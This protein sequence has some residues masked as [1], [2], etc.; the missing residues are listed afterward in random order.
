M[1]IRGAI[2]EAAR[3]VFAGIHRLHRHAF[4]DDE[5]GFD[6]YVETYAPLVAFIAFEVLVLWIAGIVN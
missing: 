2:N 3:E 5:W 4:D 1:D 6:E